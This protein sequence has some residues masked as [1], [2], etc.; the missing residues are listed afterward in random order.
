MF[1]YDLKKKIDI[2][3]LQKI[4]VAF[5]NFFFFLGLN[6]VISSEGSNKETFDMYLSNQET[7]ITR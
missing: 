3:F 2:I 1:P 6:R 5:F 7:V 4:H